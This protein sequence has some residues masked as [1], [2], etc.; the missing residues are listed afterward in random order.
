MSDHDKT[1][2]LMAHFAETYG[3]GGLVLDVG[4]LEKN[5]D[6]SHILGQQA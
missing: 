1:I 6:F 5:Y 2:D 3:F 4:S